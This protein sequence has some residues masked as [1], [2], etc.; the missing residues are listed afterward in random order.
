MGPDRV[1]RRPEPLALAWVRRSR[2]GLAPV[3]RHFLPNV[4]SP[5]RFRQSSQRPDFPLSI[6]ALPDPARI[7]AAPGAKELPLDPKYDNYDYPTTAPTP[8]NGHPGHTTPEQD[9]QVHQLRALLEQEGYTKNL[10]TLT[11]VRAR[12]PQTLPPC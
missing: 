11:L 6:S 3:R 12:R 1:Q 2:C 5:W 7:M 10:D 4:S 9:A 8:Q